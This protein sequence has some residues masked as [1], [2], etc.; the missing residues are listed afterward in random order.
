[1]LIV[2]GLVKET[3]IGD[4]FLAKSPQYFSKQSLVIYGNSGPLSTFADGSFFQAR[5]ED[6]SDA[7]WEK[8]VLA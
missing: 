7:G 2:A 5:R 6:Y 3:E 1:M 8:A 4:L